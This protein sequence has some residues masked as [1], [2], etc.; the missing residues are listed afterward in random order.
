MT[1][2]AAAPSLVCDELPAVDPDKLDANG[3]VVFWNR[4]A[5]RIFGRFG[6]VVGDRLVEQCAA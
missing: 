2:A 1:R 3:D 5:G 6:V 4:A